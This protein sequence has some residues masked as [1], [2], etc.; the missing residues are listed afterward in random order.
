M[1]QT[2]IL[3]IKQGFSLI[4][5]ER[6]TYILLTKDG[7]LAVGTEKGTIKIY[8]LET[9][10]V[11]VSLTGHNESIEWIAE[12]SNGNLISSEDGYKVK[13][14]K[15]EKDKGECINTFEPHEQNT[16]MIITLTNNRFAT[17][18]IESFA[19]WSNDEI[20][21]PLH[22]FDFVHNDDIIFIHQVKGKEELLSY[23]WDNMIKFWD[24]NT[25]EKIDSLSDIKVNGK[26][27][28]IEI[29]GKLLIG[30]YDYVYVINLAEHKLDK[31]IGNEESEF[32]FEW[33]IEIEGCIISG[34]YQS[35]NQFDIQTEKMHLLKEDI[36]E[37][38]NINQ[39][40]AIGKNKFITSCSDC[41]DINEW[42]IE[43]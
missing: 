38:S 23:G 8:N 12:I 5:E 35:L 7:R 27:N 36:Y 42:V 6:P 21:Q 4:E 11:E 19:I 30:E 10:Q 2:K 22:S 43:N 34:N 41:G 39:I 15:I 20:A 29:N 40:I 9:L 26:H 16:Q 1:D 28:Y 13:I 24:L 14:W 3:K 33:P 37:S 31:K 18:S 17:C 25:Y 32:K